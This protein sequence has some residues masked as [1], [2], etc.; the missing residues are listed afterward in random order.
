MALMLILRPMRIGMVV[1]G[2]ATRLRV[3]M[4]GILFV[5]ARLFSFMF[6]R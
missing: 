5:G 4:T 1:S 2:N 6:E 3:G